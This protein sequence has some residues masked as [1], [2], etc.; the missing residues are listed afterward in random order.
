MKVLLPAAGSLLKAKISYIA[1]QFIV[2]FRFLTS[3]RNIQILSESVN[4]NVLENFGKVKEVGPP[5]ALS[6]PDC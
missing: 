2:D 4:R 6:T 3:D 1:A 5:R